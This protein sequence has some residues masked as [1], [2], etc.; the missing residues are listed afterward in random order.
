MNED[1]YEPLE[2]YRTQ[3]QE[4]FARL[5]SEMFA[6]LVTASAVDEQCNADTVAEIN[7]LESQLGKTLSRRRLWQFLIG[8]AVLAISVSAIVCFF[9]LREW[10]YPPEGT[11]SANVLLRLLA[12]IASATMAGVLLHKIIYTN[13]RRVAVAANA[14]TEQ[15]GQQKNLAWAQLAPLN[16]L[17]DWDMAAR[18]IAQTVPRI[19]FDPYFTAQRLHELQQNFGLDDSFNDIQSVLFAQS[20]A[21]NGNPFVFAHVRNMHWG[22]KTYIG[23]KEISW[24][25]RV[26]G[27]DGKYHTALR[28]ETLVATVSKPIPVYSEDKFLLYG[29]DAAPGLTFSR[30]PSALS[31]RDGGLIHTLRKKHVL[32]KL[33]DFSRNLEDESQYT[34]MGNHDFEVLFHATD[35]NDEVEFRLLFT[36]LAQQQMLTLLRDTKTGF[37]DD[38]S[39]V[40]HYKL[41]AIY[42]RH[43]NN[44]PID[45]DPKQFA[46]YNLK[47]AKV[48]F[49]KTME[50]YFKAVYFSLA[51]LLAIP[52]YQQTRTQSAIHDGS[53]NQ[54]A[55]SW[56]HESLA[57]YHGERNFQHPQ[58]I[59]RNIIK[60]QM[61]AQADG[62][63]SIA[64]TALGYK[65]ITRTESQNIR[66]G[67]GQIHR[68]DVQWTD[69]LPV[70]QT[71]SMLLAEQ[72]GCTL[73]EY[74]QITSTPAENWQRLLRSWNT[75][76]ER[77]KYRR[78]I[79]SFLE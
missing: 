1:V 63:S 39:F 21:I 53:G 7:R 30:T 68:V 42:P 14:L 78:S 10:L 24:T 12:G 65:G 56:E 32:G 6:S 52:L 49:Q 48:F 15:V 61:I 4:K 77:G 13:Y 51:P 26:K 58:C 20:G 76:W 28:H 19:Q 44:T 74:Q 41:N 22:E 75:S 45:T 43:L 67:D 40:K 46:H 8:T 11:Q 37:G 9:A 47:D 2:R 17:Y 5:A 16:Q 34:L 64:V 60:T 29:N 50:E 71:K 31:G 33:Q 69:Y 27:N 36:P 62:A 72:P 25:A 73:Q 79:I 55:S 23:R 35:R 57:N 66:G 38:F 59:T 18:L 3:F 70:Q 54:Q